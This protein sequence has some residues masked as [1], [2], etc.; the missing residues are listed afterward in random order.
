MASLHRQFGISAALYDYFP[1]R[2]LRVLTSRNLVRQIGVFICKL[3]FRETPGLSGQAGHSM[4]SLPG[5]EQSSS[6]VGATQ[7][8]NHTGGRDM[9]RRSTLTSVSARQALGASN[10][11]GISIPP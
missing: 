8:M 4:G 3:A 1:T 5:L 7:W 11:A 6:A 9:K 2:N 10:P